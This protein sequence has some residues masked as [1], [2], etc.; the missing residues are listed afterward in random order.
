MLLAD[1]RNA[2]VGAR[3]ANRQLV[4]EPERGVVPAIERDRRDRQARPLRKLRGD[5]SG[6]DVRRDLVHVHGARC[7]ST[8]EI[9]PADSTTN[10]WIPGSMLGL[11]RTSG[12]VTVRLPTTPAA[13]NTGAEVPTAP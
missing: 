8:A 12:M 5:Q 1:L 6:G 13:S 9:R 4:A 3:K 10:R 7:P 11:K 2:T